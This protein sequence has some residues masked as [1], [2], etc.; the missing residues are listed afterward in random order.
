MSSNLSWSEMIG[1]GTDDKKPPTPAG[2]KLELI[3]P[4]EDLTPAADP[5]AYRA[6]HV[7][8]GGGRA[9]WMLDLRSVEPK[10]GLMRGLMLPYPRLAGIEYTGSTLV[11][12]EFEN[13]VVVIEGQRLDELVARLHA[14]TVTAIQ[15]YSPR[16]WPALPSEGAVVT[17]LTVLDPN[18]A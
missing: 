4:D 5:A 13:R 12:L 14:G 7:K 1:R 16:I 11:T 10:S 3:E 9:S 8:R 18:E 6:F 2:P 15:E 17:K